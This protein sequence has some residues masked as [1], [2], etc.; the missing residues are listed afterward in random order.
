MK[1]GFTGIAR[2][3]AV[4]ALAAASLIACSRAQPTEN[5]IVPVSG[6]ASVRGNASFRVLQWNVSGS[7][8]MKHADVA[9]A[10]LRHADPDVLVL[11]EVEPGLGAEGVRQM[12]SRLRGPGDTTWFVSFGAGGSYQRTA[13]A[14]RDSVRGLP[15]F[16]LVPF[17]DTGRAAAAGAV[18]DSVQSH[19]TRAESGTIG[20][21][22]AIVRL[23]GRR[24]LVVGMDLTSSGMA[25]SWRDARRQVEA[26]AIRE[27]MR[28]AI[29][30]VHPDGVI[31]AGDMNIVTGPAPLDTILSAVTTG[32][33]G[34]MR[35]ADA[36]QHDGWTTW[37]WDGRGTAF[38]G[39]RLDVV[40]YS[41]GTLVPGVGRVWNSELMPPDTLRAHHLV[42]GSSAS[43][44]RHRPVVVDFSF[45]R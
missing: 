43:I 20:T 17:P 19:P 23:G 24:L 10:V 3:A 22:G 4:A 40:I 35:A 6:N 11:D 5:S 32:P 14:S 9:L 44:N 1:N 37:T 28:A 45:R 30:R 27:R 25:G 42:A 15:E 7:A 8:W 33:L 31:A 26:V 21:N 18:P 29:A 36:V 34:P 13:I 38:N 39:G 12:L 2:C 41:S 16:A